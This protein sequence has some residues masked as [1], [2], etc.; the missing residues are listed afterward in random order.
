MAVDP[1]RESRVQLAN[2][3]EAA[4]VIDPVFRNSPQFVA[5]SLGAQFGLRLVCKVET[6][7]PVRSFKG[8]GADYFVHRLRSST[9][10][11]VCASAGNFG[12]GLAYAARRRQLAIEVFAAE[13]ASPVKIEGMRRLGAKVRLIGRDFD[14][15]KQE[16]RAHA[17]RI[18]AQ[19]V[20]DGED[21]A[22]AEG[23]GT[24]GLELAGGPEKIEVV[25]VPLGNGALLSGVA[26]AIKARIPGVRVIGVCAQGAPA[27]AHGWHRG[28]AVSSTSTSTSTSASTSASASVET[29]ADG[30]AVRV[31][32]AAALA[33][34]R[35]L[36]DDVVLVDDDALIAAMRLA[37]D[38]LGLV[39]EPAGAA[40]LAVALTLRDRFAGAVV[41]VPLCGGNLTPGQ[42]R[43]W[44]FER[45]APGDRHAGA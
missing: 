12:Q 36:V 37:F 42:A 17:T 28:D 24:I 16:A 31:P 26:C 25:L 33:D 23:A 7:N 20:E 35:A 8:R 39:I 43:D 6:A 15:A 4:Q 38:H 1:K 18:G 21:V 30:I 5:E 29:I 19:F 11:L 22:I 40:G 41:A 13:R 34:L 9:T 2:I 44:L 10:P 27:M 45:A 14:E 32:I 3:E